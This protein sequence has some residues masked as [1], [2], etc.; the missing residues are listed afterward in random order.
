MNNK[1]INQRYNE[2]NNNKKIICTNE[3]LQ[4]FI[5]SGLLFKSGENYLDKNKE[6]ISI[7]IIE[8]SEYNFNIDLRKIIK[9]CEEDRIK[10]KN[11]KIYCMSKKLYNIYKSQGL[12]V[13]INSIEYYRY[14]EKELWLV[15]TF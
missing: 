11:N 9:L 6:K 8:N 7:S 12:I 15:K 1:E 13:E 4:Y 3:E 10:S 5:I 2:L 14:F